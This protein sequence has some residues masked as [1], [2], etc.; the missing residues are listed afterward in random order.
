M[1]P[2]FSLKDLPRVSNLALR[3]E[4][5]KAPLIGQRQASGFSCFYPNIKQTN[6]DFTEV[7]V[8]PEY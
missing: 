6:P 5:V 2:I 4:G 1:N 3:G 8:I 7:L